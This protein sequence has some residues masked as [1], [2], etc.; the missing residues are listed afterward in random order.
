MKRIAKKWDKEADLILAEILAYKYRRL[1]GDMAFKLY[2]THGIPIEVTISLC[3]NI[4]WAVDVKEFERLLEAERE[5]SRKA[6]KFR[7]GIFG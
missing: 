3:E 6:S 1:P 4:G 5:K 2:S 7:K